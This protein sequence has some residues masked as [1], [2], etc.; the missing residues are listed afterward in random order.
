MKKMNNR[1]NNCISLEDFK[2]KKIEQEHLVRGRKPLYISY[3]RGFVSG[4]RKTREISDFSS[5]I[6]EMKK[7]MESIKLILDSI[8]KN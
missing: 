4:D 6:S 7:N 2:L 1:L 3:N 5:R 8:N